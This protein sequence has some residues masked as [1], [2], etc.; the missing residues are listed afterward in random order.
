MPSICFVQRMEPR[1]ADGRPT[2]VYEVRPF[3]QQQAPGEAPVSIDMVLTSEPPQMGPQLFPFAGFTLPQGV[4]FVPPF[5]AV[6]SSAIP[7]LP[8]GMQPIPLPKQESP[9]DPPERDDPDS[10]PAPT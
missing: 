9:N 2:Q 1:A 5:G 3:L 4:T 7:I 6:F 10:K 8:P